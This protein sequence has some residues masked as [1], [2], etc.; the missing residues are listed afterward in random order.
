MFAVTFDEFGG[1]DVLRINE[2]PIPVPG[3]GEVVVRVAASPVNPT[4]NLMRSGQQA[5]MMT[6]L[7]PPYIAGMEFA[8]HVHSVGSGVST[9]S[10]GQPVI[11]VVNPRRPAGG[12]H[13]QYVCV[14]AVSIASLDPSFDLVEASTVPMNSLTAQMAIDFLN[15]PPGSKV[16]VTG[17]AGVLGGYVIQL[18]KLA[19]LFVIADAKETDIPWLRRLKVDETVPR[20]EAMY[21]TVRQRW[22][23]GVDGVVDT[24]LLGTP[25]GALV[26]DG[27]PAVSV[28]RTHPIQD[29][30][31]RQ[32]AVSVIEQMANT[33]ALQRLAR[34][35]QEGAFITRIE[36][37]MPMSE[38]AEAYRITEQGGLRGRLVLTFEA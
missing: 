9:V 25:V 17:A 11:G 26:A 4:D 27:G 31:L 28:R 30:R 7:T 2:R 5:S 16:L 21:A 18:A 29:P 19:G 38:A 10:V 34:L 22:P 15:L 14:P 12:A 6:S 8:G 35:L 24:A 23:Q 32:H 37:R 36:R 1:P 3:E 13:T 33:A 20:G